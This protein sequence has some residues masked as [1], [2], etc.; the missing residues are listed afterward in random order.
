MSHQILAVLEYMEKEKGIRREEMIQAIS[1]AI[2]FAAQKGVN[3]GQEIEVNINP[4]TGA[5]KASALLRV[6]DSVGDAM[7]EIHIN[8]AQEIDP[9]VRL[10]DILRQEINP[11][12]LG[13]I[14]AQAARQ[15]INQSVKQH[16]RSRIYDEYADQVGKI[17]NGIVRRKE[18]HE[19]KGAEGRTIVDLIV[20]I[21]GTE[22]LLPQREVIPGEEYRIGDRVRALLLNIDA[23]SSS[24]E[25]MLTISRTTPKFVSALLHLE[26]SEIADES[27]QIVR[28]V[29]EP[30]Y[31]T[32]IA[33]MSQDNHIDPVGACVGARGV[34]VKNIVKELAG[35]KLD[36]IRYNDDLH[37]FLH[38]ALKPVVPQKI[39][40]DEENQ[41]IHFEV[42]EEDLA[43]VIGKKGMNARLL[44]R[45]LN[46]RL[47]IGTQNSDQMQFDRNRQKALHDLNV[48][49]GLSQTLMLALI[50]IGIT[51]PDAFEGVT[52][53]DLVSAGFSM[54]DA[55]TVIDSYKN[56][57]KKIQD[58]L[59]N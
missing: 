41:R 46:W 43:L 16:E 21:G 59:G 18:V 53:G 25:P 10:G 6:V 38:E 57:R 1:E 2:I 20:E 27:V 54:G 14:A 28:L 39:Q 58:S 40:I 55:V 33:V 42:P 11:A 35:E 34:R 19:P 56:F 37:R 7:R 52:V 49:E 50:D 32:K 44:S 13:R 22:A 8:K 17:V 47:D 15:A 12:Y 30:G 3:A 23:H 4:K 51:A 29:R 5:L 45:L 36:V 24:Q 26:V 9:D 48:I 31:R